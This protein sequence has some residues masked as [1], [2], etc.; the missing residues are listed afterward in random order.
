MQRQLRLMRR[1]RTEIASRPRATYPNRRR[2]REGRK[3]HAVRAL[4][5][6]AY[7]GGVGNAAD[8]KVSD[9]RVPRRGAGPRRHAIAPCA[10]AAA[11]KALVCARNGDGEVGHLRTVHNR[12][13][14]GALVTGRLGRSSAF[15]STPGALLRILRCGVLRGG[16]RHATRRGC[17]VCI[18][19]FG[20]RGQHRGF[21]DWVTCDDL[22]VRRWVLLPAQCP[23]AAGD[24]RGF[25]HQRRH[26]CVQWQAACA[27]GV[28]R[29]ELL[30]RGGQPSRRQRCPRHRARKQGV[31]M[32]EPSWR[33]RGRCQCRAVKPNVGRQREERRRLL[34]RG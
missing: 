27:P 22:R 6:D 33:R 11:V 28:A 17:L 2:A 8:A 32:R 18:R 9:L 25:G 1:R 5:E 21:R 13:S 20:R 31:W 34:G 24:G 10:A 19:S 14:G 15:S 29:G 26:L 3:R 4:A 12:R 30:L 23:S 16:A 7:H